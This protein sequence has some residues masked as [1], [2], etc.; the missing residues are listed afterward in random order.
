M[1]VASNPPTFASLRRQAGRTVGVSENASITQA[2]G[3]AFVSRMLR[4]I[5]DGATSQVAQLRD[6][7][8]VVKDLD[9]VQAGRRARRQQELDAV[10]EE[11]EDLRT[12]LRRAKRGGG[13]DGDGNQTI[14]ATLLKGIM[15]QQQRAEERWQ[16]WLERE[17][18]RQA[19]RERERREWE[20]N[21]AQS[22]LAGLGAEALKARLNADPMEEYRRQHEFWSE[23]LGKGAAAK[24]DF[25][26]WRTEKEFE[27]REKEI[28]AK[29]GSEERQAER[30]AR[31]LQDLAAI[32]AAVTG[33]TGPAAGPGIF[34]YTCGACGSQ[35]AVPSPELAQ[36]CPAC[37]TA[38]S[39]PGVTDEPGA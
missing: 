31:Q 34:R 15:D 38:L 21:S 2:V 33:G 16:Q 17:E 24:V 18:E 36:R 4:D 25:D 27:L 9:E 8:G 13:G 20:Q 5:T 23:L 12:E 30:Q 39:V 26:K 14:L 10:L 11:L 3:E 19:Q 1:S 22:W 29:Y 28:Q 6:V 32:A 35:F 7:I 37:G